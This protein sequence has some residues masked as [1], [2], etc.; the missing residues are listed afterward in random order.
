[1]VGVTAV[2]GVSTRTKRPRPQ[3]MTDESRVT[4]LPSSMSADF[5]PAKGGRGERCGKRALIY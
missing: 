4:F 1:M 2:S 5:R 3:R